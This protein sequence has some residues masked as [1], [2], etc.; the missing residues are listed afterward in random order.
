M[1]FA[2]GSL[3]RQTHRRAVA[4]PPSRNDRQLPCWR[5][6]RFLEQ[7]LLGIGARLDFELVVRADR[8]ERV[9]AADQPSEQ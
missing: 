7:R 1:K 5:L 8:H 9:T 3:A 2:H 6:L 4:I